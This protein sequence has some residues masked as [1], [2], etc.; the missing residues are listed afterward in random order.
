VSHLCIIITYQSTSRFGK[1]LGSHSPV[2]GPPLVAHI[3]LNRFGVYPSQIKVWSLPVYL[4]IPTT[5]LPVEG[6]HSLHL[7]VVGP[8]LVAQIH[9]L[10][11]RP[12]QLVTHLWSSGVLIC[13]YITKEGVLIHL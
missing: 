9:E 7:A 10:H 12:G 2:V 4:K 11:A 3:Q 6:L 8:P 5:L 1:Y 13:T